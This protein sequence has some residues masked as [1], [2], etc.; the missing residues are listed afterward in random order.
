[1][2]YIIVG[3]SCAGKTSFVVNTFINKKCKCEKD[4]VTITKMREY[5]SN[6]SIRQ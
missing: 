6:W 1:M 2:I 4:I 3:A 5:G